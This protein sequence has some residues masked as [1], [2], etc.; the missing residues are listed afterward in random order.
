MSFIIKHPVVTLLISRNNLILVER[1]RTDA[2]L[3]VICKCVLQQQQKAIGTLHRC[4]VHEFP[5]VLGLCYDHFSFV[6]AS[7]GEKNYVFGLRYLTIEERKNT[8]ISFYF[9]ISLFI[10]PVSSK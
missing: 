10:H 7:N 6:A 8:I 9:V 2:L 5:L 1:E 3:C 4:V